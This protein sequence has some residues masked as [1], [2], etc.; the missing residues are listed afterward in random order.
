MC[1]IYLVGFY[2]KKNIRIMSLSDC[3]PMEDMRTSWIKVIF[4]KYKTNVISNA[5]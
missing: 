1:Y 5:C 4:V 2:M 3:C